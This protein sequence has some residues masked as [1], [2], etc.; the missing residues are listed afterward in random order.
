MARRHQTHRVYTRQYWAD[1]WTLRPGLYCESFSLTAAP[2]VADATLTRRYGRV[3]TAGSH[4]PGTR[5]P[6]SLNG[7]YV[8]VELDQIT[9]T[10]PLATPRKWFGVIVEQQDDRYGTPGTD[11]RTGRQTFTCRGLEFL[12]MRWTLDSSWVLKTSGTG[13]QE[14][15]RAIGFNLGQG[16]DSDHRRKG[17]MNAGGE[18]GAPIFDSQIG[19]DSAEWTVRDIV[20]YLFTYQY[21]ADI[22]GNDKFNWIIGDEEDAMILKAL[23]P[24]IQAQGKTIKQVLDEAIDRRRLVG[25]TITVIGDDG[26]ETPRIDAF[27]FNKDQ[28]TLPGGEVIPPNSTQNTWDTD[29]DQTIQRLIVTEDDATRYH[30]V[31]AR[32]EPLTGCFTI[33]ESRSTSLGLDW[34]VATV[35]ADYNTGATTSGGYAALNDAEKCDKNEAY[36]R[37]EKFKKVFKYFRIPPAWAGTHN[38]Q[39]SCPN[40]LIS[41][42]LQSK[43]W[44]AGLKLLDKLPLLSDHDY[45][46]VDDDIVD[47]TI[48]NSQ[49]EYLRPFVVGQL[50]HEWAILNSMHRGDLFHENHT[51]DL[52]WNWSISLSMQEDVPGIVMDVAGAMQHV[53]AED[54]FLPAEA[55]AV[56]RM[57]DEGETDWK[58]FLVTVCVE[59]DQHVEA[60]WPEEAL[61][62]AD[63]FV[64][65]LI[66]DVPRCRLDWLQPDTVIGIDSGGAL[67][68]SSGGY[69]RDDRT[70][71]K[72]IARSAYAWYGQTRKALTVVQHNLV[73]T[74]AIGELITQIG[75]T[76]NRTEV[77]SVVTKLDFNVR[78]G[79]VTVTTQYAEL[80]LGGLVT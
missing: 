34:D 78:A 70:L 4:L 62:T 73:T 46:T 44:W 69:V 61:T 43:F 22:G 13:E 59:F 67:V 51:K 54:E 14:V 72:D 53:I 65:E 18:R 66:I 47:R 25:W 52:G 15:G 39:P 19:K 16:R 6:L 35:E 36:R 24:T 2:D 23:K 31:I 32:G 10:D 8:K 49:P 57:S 41:E 9:D 38:A 80:D 21:P 64:R 29:D 50:D 37:S 17:N 77:N 7:H 26:A 42:T 33:A 5:V 27:T 63:D 74:R 40:H 56:A 11:I 55:V 71:L 60:H 76:G 12:L 30:K 48:D 3:T 1:A 79:T 75:E 20:R 68:T 58:E 45:S 28:I